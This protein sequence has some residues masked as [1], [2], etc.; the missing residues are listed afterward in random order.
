M[1][2]VPGKAQVVLGFNLSEN[3]VKCCRLKKHHFGLS[4]CEKGVSLPGWSLTSHCRDFLLLFQ[5]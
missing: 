4:L 3:T 1:V 2:E 5:T